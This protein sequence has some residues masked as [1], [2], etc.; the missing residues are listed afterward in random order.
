MDGLLVVVVVPG[1]IVLFWIWSYQRHRSN[2]QR[3]TDNRM[4]REWLNRIN[5]QQ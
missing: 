1:L 4:D 3:T 2:K 5:N